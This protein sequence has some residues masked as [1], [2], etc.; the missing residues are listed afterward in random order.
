MKKVLSLTLAL[1]LCGALVLA[2][3][4]GAGSSKPAEAA[5]PD[6]SGLITGRWISAESNGKSIPTNSKIALN[7]VSDT[8]A[9]LTA[10]IVTEPGA[11]PHWISRAETEVVIDGSRISFTAHTEDN[12]TYIGEY[13][14]TTID[15]SGFTANYKGTLTVDGKEISL[16]DEESVRF[17]K[18]SDDFSNALVGTWEGHSTGGVAE[19]DDGQNH[20]WEYRGDGTY[21]YY[22]KDGENWTASANTLNEYFTDGNLLCTRWIDNGKDNREWWEIAIDGND[23]NWTALRSG[24]DGSSFTV[25]FEMTKI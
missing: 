23:M 16:G 17:V 25:T 10:W 6:V 22:V 2:G 20:R 9:Y 13:T 8:K 3:C 5:G 1:V 7:V 18:V 19:S 24:E 15:G 11:T 21:T 4:S 14:V 12:D